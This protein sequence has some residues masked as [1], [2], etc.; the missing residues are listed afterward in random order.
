MFARRPRDE[1]YSD[2]DHDEPGDLLASSTLLLMLPKSSECQPTILSRTTVGFPV[3]PQPPCAT[4]V[5]DLIPHQKPHSGT[6][7]KTPWR[8]YRCHI[9]HGNGRE[10]IVKFTRG[11]SATTRELVMETYRFDAKGHKLYAKKQ[12]SETTGKRLR[13]RVGGRFSDNE[14]R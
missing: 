1:D 5:Y 12:L 14:E 13:R 11:R 3:F 9:K 10:R 7:S 2:G 6:K 4:P 8:N